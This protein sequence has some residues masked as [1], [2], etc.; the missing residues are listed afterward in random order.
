[1]T[2]DDPRFHAVAARVQ[3]DYEDERRITPHEREWL[4]TAALERGLNRSPSQKTRRLE[5][6]RAR[7]R[8]VTGPRRR[9]A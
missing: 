6:I 3:R 4:M 2:D 9:S 5:T 1:M 8:V 7:D